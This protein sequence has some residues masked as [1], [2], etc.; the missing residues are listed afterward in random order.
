MYLRMHAFMHACMYIHTCCVLIKAAHT[1]YYVL[2]HACMHVC[3]YVTVCM[4]ACMRVYVYMCVCRYVCV[5]I[6]REPGL[7][8]V[9]Q[10]HLHFASTNILNILLVPMF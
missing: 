3:M 4:H 5:Y 7:S 10:I 1:I 8:I 9:Q 2:V 6:Y